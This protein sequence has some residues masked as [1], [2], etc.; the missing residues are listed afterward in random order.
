MLLSEA[1]GSVSS[2]WSVL[3]EPVT[4][5]DMISAS[6]FCYIITRWGKTQGAS[7]LRGTERSL[8]SRMETMVDYGQKSLLG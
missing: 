7:S 6:K 8:E 2:I 4:R 3:C 5:E 1:K